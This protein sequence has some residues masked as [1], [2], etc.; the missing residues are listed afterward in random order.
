MNKDP[1]PNNIQNFLIGNN[2]FYTHLEGLR[3]QFQ[4]EMCHKITGVL[5]KGHLVQECVEAA[6]SKL[7]GYFSQ[8]SNIVTS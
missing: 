4:V 3:K 7:Q 5:G 1:S 8:H 2:L 6:K